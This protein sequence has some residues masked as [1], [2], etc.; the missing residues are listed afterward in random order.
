[1]YVRE[2]DCPWEETQFM[3]QGFVIDTPDLLRDVQ[4]VAE[5]VCIESE[6]I[7]RSGLSAE[8]CQNVA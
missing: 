1:M 3:F 6:G 5:H 4:Q 2:L 8:R 7:G